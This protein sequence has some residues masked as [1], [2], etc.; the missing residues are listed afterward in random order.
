MS[1][2]WRLEFMTQHYNSSSLL[3]D[4]LKTVSSAKQ[5]SVQLCDPYALLM[6][7]ELQ[8]SS[9]DTK[10]SSWSSWFGCTLLTV[11]TGFPLSIG[12]WSNYSWD[13]DPLGVTQVSLNWHLAINR[14]SKISSR[15]SQIWYRMSQSQPW[16]LQDVQ[17]DSRP[18][19]NA[20]ELTSLQLKWKDSVESCGST[21]QN[22]MLLG[23]SQA[24]W[25]R[26]ADDQ[27]IIWWR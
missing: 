17:D 3:T 14:H 6:L 2:D 20:Y 1:A 7:R 16:C 27:H 26:N 15:D 11:P 10:A 9:T 5:T 22:S 18:Y 24:H 13:A 8:K 12:A 25:G 21:V 4:Q 19:V 23:S